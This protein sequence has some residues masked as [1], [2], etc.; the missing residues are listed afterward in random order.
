M[1]AEERAIQARALGTPPRYRPIQEYGVIGDCRTAA[2]VG[3]D[4]SIDWLCMPHFD[5]GALLLRLLD[6]DKGG[7]FRVRPDGADT[8]TMTYLPGTNILETIFESSEGRLRLVDFMPVRRRQPRR[9]RRVLER[10][11]HVLPGGQHSVRTHFEREIG[12]DVA[13]AHRV[14]RLATCLSGEATVEVALGVTFDYARRP[15][16]VARQPLGAGAAGAILSGGGDYLVFLVRRLPS[17]IAV[18]DH[19]PVALEGDGHELRVRVHL[20]AG[21][22]LVALIQYARST[23]EAHKLMGELVGHDFDADLDETLHFW[24]EWS[25]DCR[26]DGPYQEA[27]LRSALALK[28]CTFEPTGAI[29]AAPTTSLPEGIGGVRNWDYRYTWLR[30][31]AFTLGAL[32][33][34]GYHGEAR[35][36]FHFLHDLQIDR[37]S[38]IRIMYSI[39][40]DSGPQLAERTLDHLEGYRGSRPVRIGNGAADQR[41]LDVYGEVMDGAFSYAREEGY[42]RGR[43]AGEASRDLRDLSAMVADYVAHNWRD[44]D[45][46][47]WEV[48]GAPRT[49]VYSRAM[50]WVALDRACALAPLHEHNARRPY[51]DA[52]R[53]QIRADILAHGYDEALGSFT[54]SYGDKTLDAANLRLPLVGFLPAAD[55]R[56][57]STID[58][59]HRGLKGPDGLLYRYR[60]AGA[61]EGAGPSAEAGSSDD[62]LPGGEGAFLACTFWLVNDLCHLGRID[63]AREHFEHLVECGSPLGLFSEEIDP[64]SGAMLGN[65]PQAFTHI[66]LINSAVAIERAIE[67][68]LST[69]ADPSRRGK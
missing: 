51:W 49:F 46:G 10:V 18:P 4:G 12:N 36:Y 14:N 40:G 29:I 17:H 57:R 67:G 45:R 27:V 68:R 2:L 6:A 20:K 58:V 21:E 23:A 24:R 1:R 55:P 54:Q 11:A 47:I 41:Q 34:L 50:C 13:A 60:P 52:V 42:C 35:D 59:T 26:Y 3:P 37:G 56:M 38:D 63:E 62:G 48:R 44:L 25:T 39:R 53:A 8:S 9:K 66:G 69:E 33:E 32:G 28:L 22:R 61:R 15:A 43:R 31:S 64:D 5:S 19:A 30:D 65:Y 7:H 16:D